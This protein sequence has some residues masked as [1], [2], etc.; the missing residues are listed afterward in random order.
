MITLAIQEPKIEQFFHHSKDRIIKAL[1]FIVDN[2]IDYFEKNYDN[3]QLSQEQKD[4]LD[5]RVSS[6]HN[7]FTIGN[8]WHEIKNSLK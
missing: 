7:D 5:L 3:L 8:S 4:E 1:E 2:N 6:F